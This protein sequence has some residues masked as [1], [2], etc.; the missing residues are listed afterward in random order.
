MDLEKLIDPFPV[1]KEAKIIAQ[2]IANNPENLAQLWKLCL[3]DKKHS[4][5]ASW[6]LDKVYE[7]SPHLVRPLIPQMVLLIPQ[8]NDTS[9]MRQFLKLI[10]L[11]S[12]PNNISGEF[13]TTCFELLISKK[14]AIAVKV[15]AM[16]ILFNF[17]RQEP[18]IKNELAI[19]IE[20]GIKNESGGYCSRACKILKA[21][22]R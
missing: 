11:E 19:I 9:K 4:W 10:S 5:R 1:K 13:I 8:L 18:D 22:H 20:E 16:Q 7:I 12:L 2:T 17:S 14:S 3:S 21:L 6:L 15:Y